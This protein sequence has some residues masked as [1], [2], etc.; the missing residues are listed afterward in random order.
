M[1]AAIGCGRHFDPLW[2]GPRG[3]GQAR[4][5]LP[6]LAS[7][8]GAT[9]IPYPQLDAGPAAAALWCLPVVLDTLVTRASGEWEGELTAGIIDGWAQALVGAQGRRADLCWLV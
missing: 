7:I 1:V 6:T 9:L 2:W 5:P 4:L 8:S 3:A